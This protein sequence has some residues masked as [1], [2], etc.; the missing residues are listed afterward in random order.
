MSSVPPGVRVPQV[1]DH[2]CNHLQAAEP[3]MKLTTKLHL[4]PWS[5]IGEVYLR[6]L[7]SFRGQAIN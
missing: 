1:D 4:V 3:V 7:R 6:S 2:W 5:T